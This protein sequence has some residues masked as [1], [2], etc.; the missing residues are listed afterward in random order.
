MQVSKA[1]EG[2]II[3]A[4]AEGYSQLTL[5]AYRS[6]LITMEKYIGGKEVFDITIEDLRSFMNYLVADYTPERRNNPANIEPLSTASHHRYWK[7]MHSFYKWAEQDLGVGRPDL[8]I[9]MPD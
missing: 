8:S 2:C 3:A 6:A 7:A 4:L 9:K 5:N 1:I